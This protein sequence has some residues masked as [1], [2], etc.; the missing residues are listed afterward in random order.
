[1]QTLSNDD[2]PNRAWNDWKTKFLAVADI[3]APQTIRTVKND[4]MPWV[5]STIK[6]KMH[7]RDLLKK[8]AVKSG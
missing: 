6:E 1:M 8:K 5:T 7:Y 2:D 4:Y 3:H